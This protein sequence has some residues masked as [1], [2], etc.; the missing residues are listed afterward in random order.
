MCVWS[1][2]PLPFCWRFSLFARSRADWAFP[3]TLLSAAVCLLQTFR[4]KIWIFK[5]REKDTLLPVASWIWF[6]GSQTGWIYLP[7][8]T[9]RPGRRHGPCQWQKLKHHPVLVKVSMELLEVFVLPLDGPVEVAVSQLHCVQGA[10]V[11]LQD[12]VDTVTK[13]IRHA[14][15]L[16]WNVKEND[17]NT[18]SLN[19]IHCGQSDCDCAKVMMLATCFW[20]T[21]D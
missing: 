1:V 2:C 5:K 12:S 8:Q 17:H 14:I 20:G 3:P 15:N 13:R 10:Y 6:Y 16:G 21:R 19:T 4:V 7:S 18:H 9:N 11:D